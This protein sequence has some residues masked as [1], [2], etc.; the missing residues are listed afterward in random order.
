M[1]AVY[2]SVAKTGK[3]YSCLL[4]R[5]KAAGCLADAMEVASILVQDGTT[6]Q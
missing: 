1:I 2:I 6:E 5:M 4:M 3:P